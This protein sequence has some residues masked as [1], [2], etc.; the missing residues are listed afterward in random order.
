[1]VRFGRRLELNIHSPRGSA[2]AN[3]TFD[4]DLIIGRQSV[5]LQAMWSVIGLVLS[6]EGTIEFNGEP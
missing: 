2:E 4:V 6:L 1:M 5:S 3:F